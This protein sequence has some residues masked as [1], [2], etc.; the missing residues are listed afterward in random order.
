MS[1]PSL[2]VRFPSANFVSFAEFEEYRRDMQP[3]MDARYLYE[4]GLANTGDGHP[5]R[6]HLRPL[7][8]PRPF[9]RP[10]RGGE[11]LADGRTVPNWR[12]EQTCDCEDRLNDRARALV[13]FLAVRGRAARLDPGAAVRAGRVRRTGASAPRLAA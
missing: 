4:R 11:A 10:H 8:A 3:R 13:H 12:E 9:H 5:A 1:D 7:P 6:R 2:H